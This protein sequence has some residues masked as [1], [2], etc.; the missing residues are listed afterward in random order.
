MRP[1]RPGPPIYLLLGAA[2]AGC[3]APATDAGARDATPLRIAAAS[4]LQRAL[5]RLVERYQAES[6]ASASMTLDAS[7][8]L[9]EQ[10][11]AGAPYDVFLS[12]NEKFVRDLEEQSFVEP[13][14]GR[15][16][17][18]GSLVLCV[19]PSAAAAVK[20]LRDLAR[21]EV[22]WIAIANPEF[23]PYGLAAR[24]ALEAIGLWGALGPKIVRAESVRQA[25]VYAQR[26][27]ADVALVSRSL[28]GAD[29]GVSVIEVDPALYS[30]MVQFLGI[31]AGSKHRDEAEAFA[32]LVLGPEGQAILRESGLAPPGPATPPPA[33]ATKAETRP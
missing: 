31:V 1:L 30:P 6:G 33:P 2:L 24:Q 7:G 12:A 18:R 19:H 5:P 13:G 3:S 27:E 26:G 21:P 28:I 29:P 9:A 25:F 17:A 4:D 11:K 22:R 20:G 32:R 15:P 10:I 14:T 23:A 16:Y 8:R